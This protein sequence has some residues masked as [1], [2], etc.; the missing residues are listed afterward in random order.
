MDER[1]P[2]KRKRK[3]NNSTTALMSPAHW[4]LTAR[5]WDRYGLHFPDEERGSEWTLLQVTGQKGPDSA[6]D[7]GLS[8][9][10]A[11]GLGPRLPSVYA[12]SPWGGV[13]VHMTEGPR[14][15]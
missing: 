10:K 3:G 13:S 15:A 4:I 7:P 8:Y 14:G 2:L 12:L 5:I 1:G 9:P 11:H 6:L